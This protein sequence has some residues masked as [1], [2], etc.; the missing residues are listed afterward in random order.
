[1][2]SSILTCVYCLQKIDKSVE[3]IRAQLSDKHPWHNFHRACFKCVAS[4]YKC[5]KV[6]FQNNNKIV[7]KRPTVKDREMLRKIE[8]YRVEGVE[9]LH[10]ANNSM[11]II[12]G[13]FNAISELATAKMQ[14]GRALE[15][16]AILEERNV[17]PKLRR[18]EE[19][20]VNDLM[21]KVHMLETDLVK[22]FRTIESGKKWGG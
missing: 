7:A 2:S 13:A 4:Q 17:F 16:V 10:M 18:Q 14:F 6:M 22:Y 11:R 20:K 8:I 12:N 1:M 15:L 9:A 21:E 5:Y 3:W 19:E